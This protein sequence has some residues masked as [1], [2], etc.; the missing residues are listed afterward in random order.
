MSFAPIDVPI[1]FRCANASGAPV[2]SG[3]DTLLLSA[4]TTPTPDIIALAATLDG[5]GIV[6]IPGTTGTGFFAVATVN[7]SAAGL[8][9]ATASTPTGVELPVTVTI[10]QTLPQTGACLSPPGNATTVQIDSG[11]TPTFAIFVEGFGT[12]PFDPAVNRIVVQFKVGG[13]VRGATSVAVRTQ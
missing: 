8:V 13:I 5:D 9:S 4:S 7:L 2:V 10:C 1:T 3:L 11:E 6:N 12:I